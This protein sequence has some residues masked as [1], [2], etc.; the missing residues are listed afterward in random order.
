MSSPTASAPRHPRRAHRAAGRARQH[1][2]GAVAGRGGGARRA[3]ARQHHL[4]LGQP[5]RAGALGQPPEVAAQQ[6]RQ[7]GVDDRR[8]AAL[9]LAE[10]ARRLV[11]GRHVHVAE[12]LRGQL[13]RAPLVL[14]VAEAPQQ[15]D[16]DRLA[17]QPVQRLPQRVLVERAQHAVRARCAR[18]P[19]RAA[20]RHDR[21]R[22]ARAEP[23]QLRARLAAELLQV[24]EALGGEQGGAC[25]A[26]LEQRVR[27]HGHAVHEALDV[28]R[29]RA[30][31]AASASSTASITPSDW[32]AGVVGDLPVTSRRRRAARRR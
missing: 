32:S 16:R 5:G 1:R 20:P 29:L 3:A 9:V 10:H 28:G 23:V 21:R 25:H 14:G 4:G 27:A 7:G 13:R 18:A 26:A 22:V 24:G 17:V 8:H 31:A 11:R 15:A 30:A 6:G 2:P 12:H 19:P